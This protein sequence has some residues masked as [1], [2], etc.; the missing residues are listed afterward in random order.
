M[1]GFIGFLIAAVI[2][3][4]FAVSFYTS[5]KD[6][7]LRQRQLFTA[8]FLLLGL[9]LLTWGV[10]PLVNMPEVTSPLVFAGDVLLVAGTCFLVAAQSRIPRVWLTVVLAT[11]AAVVLTARAYYFEPTAF[12]EN[13]LLH[14]NLEGAPRYLVVAMLAFVWM[15][16]GARIT[17]LAVRSKGVPQFS[18]VV[19]LVYVTSLL[20]AA[21]FIGARQQAA[22]IGTFAV[23]CFTFLILAIIPLLITKYTR[24]TRKGKAHAGK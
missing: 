10:A 14:F 17:Q 23:L 15:P 8:A 16:L 3:S 2:I 22:I 5:F 24:I 9:A 13:G 4:F 19:A 1:L 20:S 18:G 21:M 6:L 7:N 11:F 12:V